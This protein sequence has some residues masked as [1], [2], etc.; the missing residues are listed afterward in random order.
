MPPVRR[1]DLLALL[2]TGSYAETTA[3]NY[4]GQPRPATVLVCG[5]DA[6]VTTCRERLSD[7]IGRYRVPARLLGKSGATS[8]G[9]I[10]KKPQGGSFTLPQ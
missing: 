3:L 5:S 10:A 6:E 9:Q 2:D 8:P 7:V 4:N 1:G